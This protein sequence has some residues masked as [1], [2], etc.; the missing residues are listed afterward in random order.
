MRRVRRAQAQLRRMAQ[1]AQHMLLRLTL[2][3]AQRPFCGN[4]GPQPQLRPFMWHSW[5]CAGKEAAMGCVAQRPRI[6]RQHAELGGL[7]HGPTQE[8]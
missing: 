7:K 3:A 6:D 8:A 2:P 1:P 4:T 5:T